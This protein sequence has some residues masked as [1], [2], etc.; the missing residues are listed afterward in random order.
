MIT[1]FI[2]IPSLVIGVVIGYILIATIFILLS[3]F[4]PTD[5]QIG[6]NTGKKEAER[7]YENGRNEETESGNKD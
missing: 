6:Y 4:E 1:I 3:R 7:K 5:Y 2:H